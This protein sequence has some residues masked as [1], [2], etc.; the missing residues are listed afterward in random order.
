MLNALPRDERRRRLDHSERNF[1]EVA[2]V[3]PGGA[4]TSIAEEPD[5]AGHVA[6]CR[7]VVEHNVQSE[8]RRHAVNR[9]VAH[10]DGREPV[11]VELAQSLFGMHLRL[12]IGSKRAERRILGEDTSGSEAPYMEHD[13]ANT[14]RRTPAL[15]AA[16]ATRSVP[17]WLISC[18]QL[19][20]EFPERI[21]RERGE[22][23]DGVEVLQV[24]RLDVTHVACEPRRSCRTC[25][26]RSRRSSRCR[27]RRLRGRLFEHRADD[28][29]D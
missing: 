28:G 27:A 21:V 10:R 25:R 3:E 16:R 29:A 23:H 11:A 20:A 7:E 5:P 4:M 6:P 19:A 24:L 1:G 8:P 14:K 26:S 22:V 2:H 13:D 18:V 9:R 15:F 12:R 17:S